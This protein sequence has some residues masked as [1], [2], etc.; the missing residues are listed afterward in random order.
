MYSNDVY[1]QA[2]DLVVL[3]TAAFLIGRIYEKYKNNKKEFQNRTQQE[4]TMNDEKYVL[5]E[6]NRERSKMAQG[7]RHKINGC[8]SKKCTD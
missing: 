5:R 8:K 1:R 6:T 7:S 3:L 2:K 4:I